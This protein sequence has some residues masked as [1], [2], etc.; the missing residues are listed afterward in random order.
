VIAGI[1]AG[2]AVTAWLLRPSAEQPAQRPPSPQGAEVARQPEPP[3]HAEQRP[4]RPD[5]GDGAP[6]AVQEDEGAPFPGEDEAPAD[7][8]AFGEMSPEEREQVLKRQL[9][10]LLAQD[11]N[12][13]G[14]IRVTIRPEDV[15][16]LPDDPS[17]AVAPSG[18]DARRPAGRAASGATATS[19]YPLLAQ[20]TLP[21]DALPAGT[22]IQEIPPDALPV[23]G[24]QNRSITTDPNAFQIGDERLK[25]IID[26]NQVAAMYL[27]LYKER[28]DLGIFGWAFKSNSAARNTYRKLVEGYAEPDS[29]LFWHVDNYVVW[30][31][32]DDGTTDSC[33]RE[34]EAFVEAKVDGFDQARAGE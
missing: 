23:K 31:W 34:F 6:V 9:R 30:L 11:P 32:R 24:L 19:P 26:P 5:V 10:K 8:A 17:E 22:Q 18:D 16:E 15:F 2:V 3:R 25:D 7:E 12:G 33:F 4:Q 21:A 13:T 20:L 27:A 1:V 29:M 14:E 28:N